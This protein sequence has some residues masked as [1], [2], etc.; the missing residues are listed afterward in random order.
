MPR[1]VETDAQLP[2]VAFQF[3]GNRTSA[4]GP[5]YPDREYIFRACIRNGNYGLG[6]ILLIWVDTFIINLR[7]EDIL[8]QEEASTVIGRKLLVCCVAKCA[9]LIQIKWGS[10]EARAANETNPQSPGRIQQTEPP[11]LDS[12]T[13]MM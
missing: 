6:Y 3:L 12:N 9:E 1:H 8:H 11:F 4:T 2:G 5:K 10:R 7:P 13:P